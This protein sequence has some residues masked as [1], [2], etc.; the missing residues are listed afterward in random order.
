MTTTER[1][2][3]SGNLP[4]DFK[5]YWTNNRCW[6]AGDS[7]FLACSGGL[8]SVVLANLL[9]HTGIPFTILHCNFQ[10]RGAESNRDEDFV[11]ALA[12]A[13]NVS[14]L[15]KHFDTRQ[16]MILR[17]KGLQET[18][19]ILR[20]NWFEEVL[21]GP[22]GEKQKG[23]LITAHHADDQLE[24]IVMNFFR[25][26]GIA[27]LQGMSFKRAHILRPLLFADRK[28]I[29]DFATQNGI[30]WVEDSSNIDVHYTRNRFRQVILPEIEKVFP[31]A[32]SNV[33]QTAKHL[34]AVAGIYT[35]EMDKQIAKL[36][37]N[38][39]DHIAIPINK[40]KLSDYQE[41]VIFE[42]CKQF[43]FGSA[44][45]DAVKYL[46]EAPTGKFIN[47]ETHRILKNRDWLLINPIFSAA[48]QIIIVEN[49]DSNFELNGRNFTVSV[50]E[51]LLPPD[52]S[53]NQAWLDFD[54]VS[55]PLV[56]R[57]LKT[58]D[59]FY[60]LGMRKKKKISR[61]LTDLK[62]SRYEKEKQ[63]VVESDR[64]IIWILG[65]RIDDRFKITAKTKS[66]LLLNWI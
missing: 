44:Q 36:L 21:K 63:W 56:I 55:F 30:A 16:E 19:R 24:T 29:Y 46:I 34:N 57:P 50:Q 53:Q 40:L 4:D 28:V 49:P 15:V 2:R 64:K 39:G 11:R 54:T 61:F 20:Y 5:S 3:P 62:L 66:V 9:V 58:G 45:V 26:T 33:L 22:A 23:W 8:D 14:C 65:Y 10:L 32:A 48:S 38:K 7:F 60:P 51:N 17:K 42:I 47:S 27:G 25:G 59:Y 31:N 12:E 1:T 18:A 37:E 13:L 52:S 6:N 41:A 35:N 43:G